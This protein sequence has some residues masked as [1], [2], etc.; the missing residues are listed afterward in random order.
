MWKYQVLVLCT[1]YNQVKYIDK[2]LNSLVSQCTNFPY[3]ILIHDDA[4]NDGTSDIVRRYEDTHDNVIAV[5]QKNN[6]WSRGINRF[7]YISNYVNQSKYIALCEGDDWWCDNNK[8]QKQYEYMELHCECSLCVH[9]VIFYCDTTSQFGKLIPDIKCG[10]KIGLETIITNGASYFGTN[11]MFFRSDNYCMPEAFNNWGIGDFPR[12]I[13]LASKGYVY[14]FNEVMSVYRTL[15]KG[16]WSKKTS[17]NINFFMNSSVKSIIKGLIQADAYFH[18]RYH[19]MFEIAIS[20][21]NL[22]LAIAIRDWKLYKSDKCKLAL[23]E[24][25]TKYKIKYIFRIRFYSLYSF[26][27]SIKY[28]FIR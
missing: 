14:C 4:S 23:S 2:C 1:T 8:I 18:N 27:K 28:F 10:S 24:K 12:E 21:Q 22:G 17:E 25:S 6:L 19:K 16:S 3:L 11:S 15:A 7:K 26:L 20:K 5:I 9:N 13:Y